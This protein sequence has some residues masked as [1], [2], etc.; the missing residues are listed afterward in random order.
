[1][2]PSLPLVVALAVAGCVAPGPVSDAPVEGLVG[3]VV[4]GF[5][6]EH[7]HADPALHAFSQGLEEVAYHAM[8]HGEDGAGA[9]ARGGAWL[10][11]ELVVRGSTAFVAYLGAPWLVGAVDVSDPSAPKLLDAL[12]FSNA[13]GMD[14]TASD[15]GAWIYVSVYPGAVGTLFDPRYVLENVQ[16]PDAAALPGVAIVDARD[17]SKLALAGFHPIH[18]LGPHTAV[19]HRY[20]DGREVVFADKADAPGGNGIVALEVVPTPTGGRALRPV[21]FFALEGPLEG[22]FPHDVH[23]QEHPLDGRTLL[24]AAW[25]DNGLVVLDVSDPAKPTLVSRFDGIPRGEE[26]QLGYDPENFREYTTRIKWE[27]ISPERVRAMCAEGTLQGA[28]KPKS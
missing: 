28:I 7:D 27:T 12:E 8:V 2:R 5:V 19:Y 24:Y 11:S 22:T 25:W 15:D 23:V 4:P 3:A 17:P 10:N 20:A 16:R 1:V 14:V 21:S 6:Q 18:G 9:E 13:W 26:V